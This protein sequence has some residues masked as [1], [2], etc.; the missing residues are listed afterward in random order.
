MSRAV[1]SPTYIAD[2]LVRQ[3]PGTASGVI[4]ITLEDETGIANLV[5][6][7]SIFERFRR[8][9]LTAGVLGVDGR[10]QR[11]GEVIHLVVEKL[12]DLSDRLRALWNGDEAEPGGR[13]EEHTSEL[14]SLMRISY[15]VFCLQ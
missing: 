8:T 5:V 7:P 11:E 4:F 6:W 3:R 13:S 12:T 1:N 10:V 14:Q 15:A 9:V 2:V